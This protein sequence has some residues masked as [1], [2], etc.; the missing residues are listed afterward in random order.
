MGAHGAEVAGS[1]AEVADPESRMRLLRMKLLSKAL[2]EITYEAAFRPTW[3]D[4]PFKGAL[5]LLNEMEL[6]T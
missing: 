4:T 1:S 5:V 6:A 3:V 2:Y